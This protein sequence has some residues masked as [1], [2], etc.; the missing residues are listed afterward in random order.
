MHPTKCWIHVDIFQI[1][2]RVPLSLSFSFV[3]SPFSF[4][5]FSFLLS[6]VSFSLSGT[7]SGSTQSGVAWNETTVSTNAL[8]RAYP[9]QSAKASFTRERDVLSHPTVPAGGPRLT[10]YDFL[11]FQ[12]KFSVA[13]MVFDTFS[14]SVLREDSH[15]HDTSSAFHWCVPWRS[16]E[17]SS[18]SSH[19]SAIVSVS[20]VLRNSSTIVCGISLKSIVSKFQLCTFQHLFPRRSQASFTE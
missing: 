15:G 11:G 2:K 3:L 10:P 1:Y 16:P 5:P 12:R 13:L 9:P 19:M 20:T 7:L 14:R 4:A 6:P 18:A 8:F 17:S